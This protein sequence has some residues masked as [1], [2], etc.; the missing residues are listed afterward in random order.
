MRGSKSE[1]EQSASSGEQEKRAADAAL[2][3]EL[4]EELPPPDSVR[5]ELSLEELSVCCCAAANVPIRGELAFRY[6]V[7]PLSATQVVYYRRVQN[8]DG[9]Y[10][11]EPM[12]YIVNLPE[13]LLV[14]AM[15]HGPETP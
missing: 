12:G 4:M 6:N 11:P 2:P 1:K 15:P 8:E 14:N 3:P 10:A 5:L 9:S 7:F 13:T